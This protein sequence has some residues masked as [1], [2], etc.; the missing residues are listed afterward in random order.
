MILTHFDNYT[1]NMIQFCDNLKSGQLT[2]KI[3]DR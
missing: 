3:K 2:E 1:I